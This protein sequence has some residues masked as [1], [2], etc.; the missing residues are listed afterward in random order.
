M[1]C[2]R[3]PGPFLSL[4]SQQS[5]R[6]VDVCHELNESSKCH[7]LNELQVIPS[8]SRHRMSCQARAC[9]PCIFVSRSTVAFKGWGWRGTLTPTMRSRKGLHRVLQ[10]V[11]VCCSVLQCVAVCCSVLQCVAVCRSVSQC[12]AVCCSVLQCV[13]VCCCWVSI[14]WVYSALTI[15][16][17]KSAFR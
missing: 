15:V 17:I 6:V 14:V 4:F 1:L 12:V 2:E 13:A 8:I 16:E 10:C 9:D 3:V 5:M 11:A 7:E